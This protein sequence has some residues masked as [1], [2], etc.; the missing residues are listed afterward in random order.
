MMCLVISGQIKSQCV[1]CENQN[2]TGTNASGVGTSPVASGNSSFAG[3]TN[4]QATGQNSFSFGNQSQATQANS[5]A[6]GYQAK[7]TGISSIALGLNVEATTTASLVA[8]RNLKSTA[9]SAFVI[10]TGVDPGRLLI[11][12]DPYSLMVGFNSTLST[13]YVGS[14]GEP[15]TTGKVGVGD[16]TSPTAK[17]HVLSDINEAAEIR[18]EHRTTGLRQYSQIY[19]GTSTIRGG[20]DEDFVFTTSSRKNIVFQTEN[21]GVLTANPR[22]P[23]HVNGNILLT[24]A[25][26]S[27]LFADEAPSSSNTNPFWGKWGIEYHAG[28]LNFWTPFQW[29]DGGSKITNPKEGDN[30]NFKLFLSDNGNVGV[31][32][33]EPLA[34][35]HVEGSSYL[36]GRTAIGGNL[37]IGCSPTENR[38]QVEGSSCFNGTILV[39]SFEADEPGLPRLI[40]VD[41]AGLLLVMDNNMGDDLGDHVATHNIQLNNHFIT[42]DDMTSTNEG[43]YIATDGRVGL[44]TDELGENDLLTV[45]G[46]GNKQAQVRIKSTLSSN[47]SLHLESSGKSGGI[48]ANAD[49]IYL[50]ENNVQTKVLR[51]KDGR[52]SIGNA[53]LLLPEG[54]KLFVEGGITTEEVKVKL[55]A[56]WSD[57]VFS[58]DYQLM[59]LPA[60]ESY[61]QANQHLPEIP[62]EE[63]VRKNGID[64]AAMNALLLQKIEELTLYVIEQEKRIESLEKM[65]N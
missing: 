65:R 26:S 31:G 24:S 28:G 21:V 27:L 8:G 15:G 25:N 47:A 29:L 64:L 4:S 2:I 10:G 35:F 42:N 18:L 6:M 7:A 19:M 57:F 56:N 40:G 37:A 44:N 16:I 32:T 38:L 34:R 52:V 12:N 11:N 54:H 51:I 50:F 60:L 58:S 14:G 33:G 41:D 53:P 43:I 17:L 39:K 63:Q 62:T 61:I 45:L 3:G 9:T 22:Q 1:N 23:L 30:I 49:G 13:L 36:N 20:N 46:T 48:T 59:T 5:I 55:K